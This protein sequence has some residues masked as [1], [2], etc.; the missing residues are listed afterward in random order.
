MDIR[1]RLLHFQYLAV[2]KMTIIVEK[3]EEN[4]IDPYAMVSQSAVDSLQ[5]TS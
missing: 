2:K 4:E 1:A 3:E 5:V